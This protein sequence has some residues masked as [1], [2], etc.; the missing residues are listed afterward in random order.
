MRK[1]NGCIQSKIKVPR[2]FEWLV[3]LFN[4]RERKELME[5]Q[6]CFL[7]SLRSLRLIFCCFQ[8]SKTTGNQNQKSKIPLSI[9]ALDSCMSFSI[10]LRHALR[11]R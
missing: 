8:A 4:R 6:D 10:T 11:P 5:K 2:Y 9:F 3:C 1:Q 7:R